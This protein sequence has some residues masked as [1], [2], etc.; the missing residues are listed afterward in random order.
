[1]KSLS[2]P[3]DAFVFDLEDAVAATD[4]VKARKTV[5]DFVITHASS[6]TATCAVRVNCPL[7]TDWG[8]SDLEAVGRIEGVD[9][10]I[11]PKVEDHH[12]INRASEIINLYR[13]QG[14]KPLPIWT[15]I[16]TPR[17][18]LNAHA[19]AK[20]LSVHCLVFGSNDLTK[21]LHAKHTFHRE[22]LLFSMAQ[23]ILAA[24]AE[25]KRVLDGVHLHLQDA[26]G[27][28]ASCEQGRN[29]GFDGKTLI[30]PNQVDAA[31]KAYS[32]SAQEVTDALEVIAAWEA[33]AARGQSGV[34]SISGKMIEQLHVDEAH[35]V[36]R[37]AREAGSIL[38]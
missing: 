9:A 11:L 28:R 25:K 27:L 4:K 26:E 20:H 34:L 16:E 17:G 3:A 22:P 23:C 7:S 12:S 36:I 15:M 32:P 37:E 33:A 38:S 29:M 30:H 13:P 10:V 19:I 24:R 31:N 21:E 2:L 35:I 18:V 6:L 8:A 14:L 5:C 1:L